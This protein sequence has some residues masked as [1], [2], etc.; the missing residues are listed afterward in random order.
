[1]N[2][3]AEEFL[4]R[5]PRRTV[6]RDRTYGS[7][8]ELRNWFHEHNISVQSIN[9]VTEGVHARRTRLLFQE[10][11]GKSV[12]I[13]IIAVPNPDY[14]ARHWWRYSEGVREVIG[15]TIVYVYARFFYYPLEPVQ[16][17]NHKDG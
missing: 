11:F 9:V 3:V 13:G 16:V 17:S 4:Q 12:T 14:E 10:A 8:V 5:V 15:E 7:A 2:G 6:D 1:M